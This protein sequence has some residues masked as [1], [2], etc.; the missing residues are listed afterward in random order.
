MTAAGEYQHAQ[1]K[2][3]LEDADSVY[4]HIVGNGSNNQ[5]A[6]AHT[7]DWNGNAVFA[8]TVSGS[9]ADY[10]EHFEWLDGNPNGEDR[11]GTIVALEGDKIRPANP[12]DEI[13]GI[14][15]GTA[16]VIGDNAEW[17][18]H[19]KYL[20][21]SYGRVITEMVEEFVEMENQDTGEMELVSI[22]YFPHR[23]INPEWDETLDYV[24]RCDRPEWA[25]VGLF[26][27]VYVTDD[28]TC[29]VGGYATAG[30]CGVA[31]AS[32]ERTNIR[33]MKRIAD[34][35]VLAFLK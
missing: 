35:I 14:V 18:W 16:M 26:G 1:G 4:A 33:V 3:G 8:G 29:T 21:D 22:G 15:S 2:F 10:A 6:N 31:T 23:K 20:T 28:G 34:N 30:D 32:T 19:D 12:E 25:V 13:L 24:R 9:G 5:H 17:E 11:V 7:L 27:K